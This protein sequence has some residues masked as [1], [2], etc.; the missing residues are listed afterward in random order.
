MLILGGAAVMNALTGMNLYAAC[1]LIPLTV[2]VYTLHGGLMATFVSAYLHT[3][4]ALDMPQLKTPGPACP[5][6]SCTMCI[7]SAGLEGC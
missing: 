5:S 4:S 2:V 1:M 3:V 7:P 6:S